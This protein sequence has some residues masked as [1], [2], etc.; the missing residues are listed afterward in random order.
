MYTF[1]SIGDYSIPKS[2]K[3]ARSATTATKCMPP[4]LNAKPERLNPKPYILSLVLLEVEAV[5][6]GPFW[7]AEVGTLVGVRV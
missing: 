5:F 4:I 1:S 2:V 7:G 6:W 3:C